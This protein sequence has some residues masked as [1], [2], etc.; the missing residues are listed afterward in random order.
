MD[1]SYLHRCLALF[2]ETM[3]SRQG[4]RPD[5]AGLE[6][7]LEPVRRRGRD[8]TYADLE[9][10]QN[11]RYWDF[12]QFWRFPGAGDISHELDFALMSRLI[13]R[14]PLDEEHAIGRLH[15]AFKYI[16]NVS[17]VLRFLHPD[18]YGIISPPVEKVL[19]VR[20]GRTEVETYL[21][22]L[23]DLRDVRDHHGMARAADAD[24]ALWVLQERVLSSY[25]DLDLLRAFRADTWLLRRRAVNLLAELGEIDDAGDHLDL[26]RALADVNLPL[27][28]ILAAHELQRRLLARLGQ[29]GPSELAALIDRA[30]S[31]GE[32]PSVVERWR[33]AAAIRERLLQPGGAP[34]RAETMA[35]IEEA[36]RLVKIT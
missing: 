23:R 4:W 9:T 31:S 22:Y 33:R 12:R 25:R 24:M 2:G 3:E 8:L 26:A 11:G 27:A 14:L 13:G 1:G 7:A 15:V 32:A 30:A 20:R 5:Y 18:Q 16:E 17:V 34:T 19:E 10:I 36:E 35:L 21:N 29:A 6:R 28:A